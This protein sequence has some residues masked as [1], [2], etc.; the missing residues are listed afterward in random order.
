M[1]QITGEVACVWSEILHHTREEA[2][3]EMMTSHTLPTSLG[4]P[5]IFMV[6]A[7]R[8]IVGDNS[9]PLVTI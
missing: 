3:V 2:F 4:T 1:P 6:E 5:D 8:D 9:H 7:K